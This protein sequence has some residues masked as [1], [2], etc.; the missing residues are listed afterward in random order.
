MGLG[1]RIKHA[2]NRMLKYSIKP[3]IS[4]P[5]DIP[6]LV[7]DCGFNHGEPGEISKNNE[8]ILTPTLEVGAKMI[9]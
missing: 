9:D 7:P 2:L 6:P 3:N 4:R 8:N 1:K 5:K